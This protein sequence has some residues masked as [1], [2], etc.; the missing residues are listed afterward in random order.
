MSWCVL[1]VCVFCLVRLLVVVLGFCV[2]FCVSYGVLC[3]V[4]V[5]LWVVVLLLCECLYLAFL[6]VYEVLV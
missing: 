6:C 2:V 5:L 3:L 4:V 1:L